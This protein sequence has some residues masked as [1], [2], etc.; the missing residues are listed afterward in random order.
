[1]IVFGLGFTTFLNYLRKLTDLN[2]Q[3]KFSFLNLMKQH[4]LYDYNY[5]ND[6]T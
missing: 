2:N 4:K 6:Y 5:K 1:M 3:P